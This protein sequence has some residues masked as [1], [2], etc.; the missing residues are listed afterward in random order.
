MFGSLLT[1]FGS[2]EVGGRNFYK[3]MKQGECVLLY[4]GGVREVYALAAWQVMHC[5][6][7]CLS[8][9]IVKL[10]TS[11]CSGS[12]LVCGLPQCPTSGQAVGAVVLTFPA[13]DACVL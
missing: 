1:T 5:T 11:L 8:T 9:P 3:L 4:P 10:D 2:V 6:R 7:A 12:C 13:R